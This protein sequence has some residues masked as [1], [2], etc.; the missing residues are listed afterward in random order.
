M[1]RSKKKEAQYKPS[2]GFF[3]PF[4]RAVLGFLQVY[5]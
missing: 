2:L 1:T 3:N 4:V 5:Y